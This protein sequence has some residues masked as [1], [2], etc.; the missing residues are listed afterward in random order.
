MLPDVRVFRRRSLLSAWILI[1]SSLASTSLWF[2]LMS[3]F[4]AMT[5]VLSCLIWPMMSPRYCLMSRLP[6]TPVMFA[7]GRGAAGAGD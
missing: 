4:T 5:E 7:D 6:V 2:F 1:L 3:D